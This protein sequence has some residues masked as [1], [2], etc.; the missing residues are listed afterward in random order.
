MILQRFGTWRAACV[1]A[2]V[3]HGQLVRTNYERRWNRDQLVD[4]VAMYLSGA[5]A[6]GSFADYERWAR[7]VDGAPSGQT[8]RT[9]LGTW[10][11][12]KAEAL[13]RLAGPEVG[14]GPAAVAFGPD[15]ERQ[16]L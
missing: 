13:G 15:G 6:R 14:S 10:S 9:Q 8:I 12:A 5:A 16:L 1:L 4:A 3:Q 2:G 7:R 11:Q